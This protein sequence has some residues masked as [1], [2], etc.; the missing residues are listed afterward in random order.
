M[1]YELTT[2]VRRGHSSGNRNLQAGSDFL[3]T[4]VQVAKMR[5]A[6]TNGFATLRVSVLG[7]AN[8]RKRDGRIEAMIHRRERASVTLPGLREWMLSVYLPDHLGG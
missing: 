8:E 5:V 1:E 7:T 3:G 2:A 4:R 6:Q